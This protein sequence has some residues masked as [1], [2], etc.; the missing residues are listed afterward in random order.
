VAEFKKKKKK[1][2]KL[3]CDN[4]NNDEH[5]HS[6]R[7]S[8]PHILPPQPLPQLLCLGLE[9]QGVYRQ[10]L[11]LATIK[12]KKTLRIEKGK[13]EKKKK[14]RD[15][16]LKIIQLVPSLQD[17]LNIQLHDIK[18]LLD[19]ALHLRDLTVIMTCFS[20]HNN[21]NEKQK[22]KTL[23]HRIRKKETRL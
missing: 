3:T 7:D 4:G 10:V 15:L 18:H 20:N 8:H 13:K 6:Y 14:R 11:R 2:D 21:N 5:N 23:Q 9:P 17:L 16:V 1:K 22:K 19:L 12:K